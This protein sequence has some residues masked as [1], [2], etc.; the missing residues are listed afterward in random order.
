MKAQRLP[1]DRILHEVI[2]NLQEI[3]WSKIVMSAAQTE[4]PI[5]M[6]ATTEIC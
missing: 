5:V 6:V 4:R 3:I 1:Q 2:E